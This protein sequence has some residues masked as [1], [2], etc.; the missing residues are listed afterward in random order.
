MDQGQPPRGGDA[1][2]LK[3]EQFFMSSKVGSGHDAAGKVAHTGKEG[4]SMCARL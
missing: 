2:V 3:D 1:E 4:N